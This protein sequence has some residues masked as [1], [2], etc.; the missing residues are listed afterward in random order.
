MYR[1][2][3]LL[4][5]IALTASASLTAQNTLDGQAKIVPE[6]E[7]NRQSAF[8]EAERE[9][10]LGHFEKAEVQYKKFLYDNGDNAAAWYGL[11]RTYAEMKDNVNALDAAAK[12]VSK[13]PGNQWYSIFQ[14]DLLESVGQAGDAA[15][16]YADLTKRFPEI[17]EFYERLAYLEVLSGNPK[18]GLKA[19]DQLEKITGVT[20]VTADKK[21]VI[22]LGMGNI[23]KAA[24]ELEKLADTYPN[25]LEYRHRIAELYD[26]VGDKDA[27]RKVYQDILRRDPY[28][29]VAQIAVLEKSG[30]DL[31]YLNS[32]KPYFKDPN[33]A[34]DGKIKELLPYF[35]KMSK[36]VD[37]SVTEVLLELAI[38]IETAHPD[39]P[40]AWSVSG[41][42]FYY[43]DKQEE[44]LSRY[45]TCIRLNPGVF[46]VWENMLA[47]LYDQKDYD[48]LL[49]TAEQ[50]MD[51][52]PNQAPAY[53]YYGIAATEKGD[54][55]DALAQLQQA[56]L[57]AGSDKLLWLNI[58]DQ[59][60]LALLRKNDLAGAVSHFEQLVKNG[61]ENH[62]GILE[63]M[64]DALS[65][66]G[67]SAKATDFWQKANRL[68]P[69]PKLQQK[70]ATGKL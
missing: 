68:A 34:L 1:L 54:P 57:M 51:A 44:A 9:R 24:D 45:R 18:E 25:R 43:A 62:P 39:D 63:H 37:A 16:I 55:D 65:Q 10:L 58:Q 64:G 53:Y 11:A 5:V 27:A 47:I 6:D 3:F 59:I 30:S 60:G 66:Q 17:P 29:S 69:S 41:D 35:E 20:E 61:G 19:L 22:Y 70:I 21:H 2:Y 32:L 42:L 4:L 8:I 49:E 36:G 46:T 67:E 26:S 31:A 12:A 38:L 48:A 7:V 40:K 52:F 28:D 15:R 33:I 56:T 13:D 50:A 23:K 14:A